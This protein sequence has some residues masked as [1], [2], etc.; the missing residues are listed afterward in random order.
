M[1]YRLR[2]LMPGQAR[3]RP[4]C[5]LVQDPGGWRCVLCGWTSAGYRPLTPGPTSTQLDLFNDQ[6]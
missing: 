2:T 1:T 3:C 4:R 6:E 5:E